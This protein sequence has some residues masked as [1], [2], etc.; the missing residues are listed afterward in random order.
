MAGNTPHGMG[1][2]KIGPRTMAFPWEWR[3]RRPTNIFPPTRRADSWEGTVFPVKSSVLLPACLVIGLLGGWWSVR[4]GGQAQETG[5]QEAAEKRKADRV[6]PDRPQRADGEIRDMDAFIAA[7]LARAEKAAAD[8]SVEHRAMADWTD[9]EVLAALD[10]TADDLDSLL[11][12]GGGLRAE[13]FREYLRRDFDAGLAWFATQ[14]TRWQPQLAWY[15]AERWPDGRGEDLLR[16]LSKHPDIASRRD[17]KAIL[18]KHI[19]AAAAGGAGAFRATL[20]RLGR[21]GLLVHFRGGGEFIP[22]EGFAFAEFFGGPPITGLPL[23][24]RDEVVRS[25]FKA[26]REAAFAWT[27]ENGGG[28]ALLVALRPTGKASQDTG[29][30]LGS[31]LDVL[32]PEDRAAFLDGFG[33]RNYQVTSGIRLPLLEGAEDPQVRE[34]I[35]SWLAQGLFTR[36][37]KE[38]LEPVEHIAEPEERLRFLET[39]EQSP[40]TRGMQPMGLRA[41]DQET[42]RGKLRDWGAGPARVE[43]IITHLQTRDAP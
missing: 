16:F 9:A 37:L 39:L 10:A 20:E 3:P 18:T 31:K 19:S 2:A 23:Y 4:G 12:D 14:D 40:R 43:A 33:T 35:R 29:R 25:W 11:V 36:N 22:P 13:I 38:G 8:G 27:M 24:Y 34:E 32:S 6:R 26:D 42:L 5:K 15:L 7:L 30:W 17:T 28:A 41:A 21:E 1:N